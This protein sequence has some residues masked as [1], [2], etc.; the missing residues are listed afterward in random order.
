[1]QQHPFEEASKSILVD[2][3]QSSQ[4]DVSAEQ[5]S[6][7]L[8]FCALILRWNRLTSLVQATTLEQLVK[9][10]VIDCL[11]AV[12]EIRGPNIVDVGSGAGFPGIVF[13][14][15]RPEW[16][17]YL[18]ETNQRRARFLT[19][20]KIELTLEN[21]TVVNS[22]IE[23][24]NNKDPIHCFTSRA[25][26]ALAAFFED[27]RELANQHAASKPT[28]VALKGRVEPEEL[29]ALVATGIPS[30]GILVKRLAVPGR[31]HRHAVLFEATS[32]AR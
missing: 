22:R 16:H 10:H 2:Y 26:S 32:V 18:V 23:A 21:V 29:A 6:Q 30:A 5:I 25:Y 19:Q 14:V 27:C 3:L 11:A 8:N 13:A 1:M 20:A 15:A 28:F 4:L 7:L 12:E 17:F 24:W 31:E 9:S